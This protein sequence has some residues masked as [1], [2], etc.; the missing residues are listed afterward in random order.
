MVKLYVPI[1]LKNKIRSKQQTAL[2][3]YL[4]LEGWEFEGNVAMRDSFDNLIT[5]SILDYKGAG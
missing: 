4:L 1:E 2:L 5:V 3:E